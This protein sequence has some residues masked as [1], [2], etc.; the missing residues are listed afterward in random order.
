[1]PDL[2]LYGNEVYADTWLEVQSLGKTPYVITVIDEQQNSIDTT[3]LLVA[4]T[5]ITAVTGV[6]LQSDP[7]HV[8]TNYYTSGTFD[9]L[10]G[11]IELGSALPVDVVGVLINY[12][13]IMRD[14]LEAQYTAIGLDNTHSFTYP[15][16]QNNAK[17]LYFRI[18]VPSDA[19][20]SGGNT[21]SFRIRVSY[22]Q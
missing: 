9:A 16:P 19:T 13:Y 21:V 20:A 5:E 15:I 12:T 22:K 3:H 7:T 2:L 10:T 6:W 4:N 18:N 14:D 17:L 11:E 1:M 8:G